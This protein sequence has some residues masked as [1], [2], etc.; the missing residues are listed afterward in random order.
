MNVYGRITNSRTNGT[1]S[2]WASSKNSKY[3]TCTDKETAGSLRQAVQL[4][5]STQAIENPTRALLVAYIGHINV[6]NKQIRQQNY[7]SRTSRHTRACV[8]D[9]RKLTFIGAYHH[10]PAVRV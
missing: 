2:Y 9:S 3:T 10:K 4:P 1:K 7:K 8:N 6:H 5:M